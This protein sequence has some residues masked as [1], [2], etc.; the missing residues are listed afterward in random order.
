MC[1]LVLS[2]ITHVCE[3]RRCPHWAAGAGRGG[4]GALTVL[5]TLGASQAQPPALPAVKDAAFQEG[6]QGVGT[7]EAGAA[8][9]AGRFLINPACALASG[10]A[11]WR[12]RG[13]GVCM[14]SHPHVGPMEHPSV[15]SPNSPPAHT[16]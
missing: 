9:A 8:K 15:L 10:E 14:D 2:P 12:V 3:L 13:E 16:A 6:S 5:E 1:F 11:V 4:G 7:G